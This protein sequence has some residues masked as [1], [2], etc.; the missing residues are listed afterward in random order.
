MVARYI[1]G[2][3]SVLTLTG[4]FYLTPTMSNT[5]P[6]EDISVTFGAIEG[7][8]FIEIYDSIMSGNEPEIVAEYFSELSESESIPEI[9]GLDHLTDSERV[10]VLESAESS[11][12]SDSPLTLD[13]QNLVESAEEPSTQ[14]MSFT[15]APVRGTATNNRFTWTLSARYNWTTCTLVICTT[16]SWVDFRITT[17]P[18][19]TGSYTAVNFTRGG[20]GEVQSG[21]MTSTI[22]ASGSKID[23]NTNSWTFSTSGKQWNTPHSSTTGKTYQA[24]YLIKW[25]TP[26]GSTGTTEWKTGKSASCKAPTSTAAFRCLFPA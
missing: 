17:N 7:A 11:A 15:S 13:A 8:S 19:R 1:V 21:S 10:E 14:P 26:N 22:Y 5:E 25:R 18:G 20:K 9:L 24:Y 2:A 4:T 16:S 3:V 23:T 12:S 6:S